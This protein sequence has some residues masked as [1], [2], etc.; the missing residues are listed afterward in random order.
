MPN[1]SYRQ[2]GCSAL[3]HELTSSGQRAHQPL[4][5]LGPHVA[6]SFVEFYSWKPHP[7]NFLHC[8]EQERS[9]LYG[10]IPPPATK[11][12]VFIALV[13]NLW[14]AAESTGQH[15]SE[16]SIRVRTGSV[17]LAR[18]TTSTSLHEAEMW[19][20][21]DLRKAIPANE[22]VVLNASS[23]TTQLLFGGK[24]PKAPF[25]E[26]EQQ[27]PQLYLYLEHAISIRTLL[28]TE[29]CT[30]STRQCDE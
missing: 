24:L 25:L 28:C 17:H 20:K 29:G 10:L 22:H 11:W 14:A 2:R 8:T 5:Y 9:S 13:W 26:T 19:R 15:S 6:H 7:L 18:V 12:L 27:Q 3:A 16:R 1:S 23:C 21:H 4:W 30:A